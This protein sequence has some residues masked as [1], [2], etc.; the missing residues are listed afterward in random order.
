M[1][2]HKLPTAKKTKKKFYNKYIYKISL[3]IPGTSA[4]R[5]YDFQQLMDL[6]IAEPSSKREHNWREKVISDVIDYK[7]MWIDLAMMMSSV[8]CKSFSKRIEGDSV[9]FYTNDFQLYEKLG[10]KFS[11]YVRSRFQPKEG[12]ENALLNS[13]KEIFVNELPYGKYQYRAYLKPHRLDA[14]TRKTVANWMEKQV[15][16]ITFTDS[17][18]QWLI[19]TN[20]N[21]DR[22]YIHILDEKTMLM[23]QLRAPQLLGKIFK[24]KLNR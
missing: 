16:N 11:K 18:K 17:I 15:P 4:L 7:E 22:R 21:W 2:L 19:H 8:D 14:N 6:C 20:E 9:D 5:W 1:M 10:N 3:N 13:E 23:I 12:T 24:Y